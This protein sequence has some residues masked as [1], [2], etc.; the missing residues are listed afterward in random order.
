MISLRRIRSVASSPAVFACAFQT[1][2]HDAVG[3]ARLSGRQGLRKLRDTRRR[4]AGSVEFGVFSAPCPSS[5]ESAK[6]DR[7][8]DVSQRPYAELV[9]SP[10]CKA[11]I[12]DAG[13]PFHRCR[14]KGPHSPRAPG[15][16]CRC[17]VS[18]KNFSSL[19]G[20]SHPQSCGEPALHARIRFWSL[21]LGRSDAGRQKAPVGSAIIGRRV[22]GAERKS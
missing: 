4:S 12:A 10:S 9:L 17:M 7:R 22:R 11:G 21:T 15:R 1:A 14:S 6:F 19:E 2:T 16:N 8:T 13:I 3:V 20:R 5:H 18:R